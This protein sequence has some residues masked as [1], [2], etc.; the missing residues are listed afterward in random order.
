M[1]L[2]IPISAVAQSSDY[3]NS[4]SISV[5]T[6]GSKICTDFKVD[7]T[8]KMEKVGAYK[9]KIYENP[10]NSSDLV[11]TKDE[12]DSGMA[13]TNTFSY[14]NIVSYSAESG[15]KYK[16]VVTIF[17]RDSSGSDSRTVTKYVT[18]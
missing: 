8:K 17:A 15:K 13:A 2:T 7:A 14:K 9:I 12:F 10:Y 18:T 4:Y 1:L 3:I 6:S 11:D 16:V 5:Y